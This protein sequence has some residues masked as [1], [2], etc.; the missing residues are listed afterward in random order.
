M[1]L[2]KK[3]RTKLQII[4]TAKEL[5]EKNGIENVT[6][7]QIAEEANVCR[8]TVF[9]H[10]KCTNDLLFS[11]FVQEMGDLE[12]HCN[13]QEHHGLDFIKTF[14]N[15]LISDVSNYPT[16][17]IQLA[18][19]AIL[20]DIEPNPIKTIEE[21]VQNCL[22]EEGIDD[23]IKSDYLANLIVGAYFGLI[24]HYKVRNHVFDVPRMQYA[25]DVMLRHILGGYYHD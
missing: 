20:S 15:K 2:P 5:F 10:F 24:T 8:T 13:E 14:F 12:T 21:M 6:F 18:N 9:N 16:L 7:S 3:E 19:N 11:I 22:R 17:A 1:A 25:F 4:H 23:N